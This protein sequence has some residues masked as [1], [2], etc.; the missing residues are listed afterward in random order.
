M[1]ENKNVLKRKHKEVVSKI[2]H[3]T[4]KY[5]YQIQRPKEVTDDI[6]LCKLTIKCWG[7]QCYVACLMDRNVFR[8][9][10]QSEQPY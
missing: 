5:K 1:Q 10:R 9:D 2:L 4:Y 8:D 3:N 6:G 7:S